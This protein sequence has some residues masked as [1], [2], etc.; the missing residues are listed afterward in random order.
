MDRSIQSARGLPRLPAPRGISAHHP[1]NT[2]HRHSDDVGD[3]ARA[4]W[5]EPADAL[6]RWSLC[7]CDAP[8]HRAC[9]LLLPPLYGDFTLHASHRSVALRAASAHG[10]LDLYGALRANDLSDDL[11][12]AGL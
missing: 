3:T 9:A 11:L 1:A 7:Q 12:L 5:A 10:L 4:W 6:C 2:P 8:A